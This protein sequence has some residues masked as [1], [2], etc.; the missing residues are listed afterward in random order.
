MANLYYDLIPMITQTKP[1]TLPLTPIREFRYPDATYQAKAFRAR[2]GTLPKL[3]WLWGMAAILLTGCSTIKQSLQ[4]QSCVLNASQPYDTVHVNP[5][6]HNITLHWRNPTSNEPFENIQNV[7]DWLEHAGHSIV[8]VTN[9]GIFEPGLVPTGLYVENG[10]ELRPLNLEDGYGNFYLKPNGVFFT[11]NNQFGILESVRFGVAKP[12]V[13]Y[14]LQSGPLLLQNNKIHPA[15][16]PGSKNCRLRNGIGISEDGQAIIAITN[17]AVNF[18]DFA[19]WFRDTAGV[20]DALYLDGAI[21]VLHTRER[22]EDSAEAYAG[23]LAVTKKD[24]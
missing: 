5:A 17:G 9:A 6:L 23:F 15:F 4:N 10:R 20:T 13:D 1:Q 24:P 22:P 7:V 3:F 16:T 8:T 21:S 14:A 12:E 11:Q 19:S 18:F 2:S